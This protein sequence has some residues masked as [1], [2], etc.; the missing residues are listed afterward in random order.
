[1]PSS[2]VI[3]HAPT[4]SNDVD[5][6][7]PPLLVLGHGHQLSEVSCIPMIYSSSHTQTRIDIS[8]GKICE[9]AMNLLLYE[10]SLVPTVETGR[11][12]P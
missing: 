2:E 3:W 10:P 7:A 11:H 9:Q 6:A 1:M 8:Q 12:A 5:I 4:C